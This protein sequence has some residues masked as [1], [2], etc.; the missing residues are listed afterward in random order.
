MWRYC[1]VLLVAAALAVA[2]TIEVEPMQAVNPPVGSMTR[3][4]KVEVQRQQQLR[5]LTAGEER[6]IAAYMAAYGPRMDAEN[7][8]ALEASLRFLVAIDQ[9]HVPLTR[10]PNDYL[11]DYQIVTQMMN[12]VDW[13]VNVPVA[14]SFRLPALGESVVVP[15]APVKLAP[16]APVPTLSA[17][18][19]AL[20]PV[21]LELT[22]PPALVC[23][24]PLI[25][26]TPI[27]GGGQVDRQA[28]PRLERELANIGAGVGVWS[29]NHHTPP[30]PST[31]STCGPLPP[32]L[33]DGTGHPVSPP[34]SAA[35]R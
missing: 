6:A 19:L 12:R 8:K 23:P 30:A 22:K 1:V 33:D 25:G 3:T 21:S 9:S 18:P 16:L 15:T 32:S 17:V 14:E 11:A 28:G 27:L 13:Y 10:R 34:P 35:G 31:P 24:K 7:R 2:E 20:T 29:S 26:F 5:T 4:T